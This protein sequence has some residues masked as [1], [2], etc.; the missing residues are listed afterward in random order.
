MMNLCASIIKHGDILATLL[1][2]VF[3]MIALSKLGKKSREEAAYIAVVGMSI[4]YLFM[5]LLPGVNNQLIGLVGCSNILMCRL[6]NAF[7]GAGISTAL[8]MGVGK[9]LKV[10]AT[11]A[12]MLFMCF[13]VGVVAANLVGMGITQQCSASTKTE[14]SRG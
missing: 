8:L 10:K 9:H 4:T 12:K 7:V 13:F 2:I 6:W 5:V 3:T 1:G 11:P 14:K